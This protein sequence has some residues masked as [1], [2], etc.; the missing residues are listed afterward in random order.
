MLCVSVARHGR[1]DTNY[2]RRY[3]GQAEVT[4]EN[5]LNLKQWRLRTGTAFG[6]ATR[7]DS[8]ALSL[9]STKS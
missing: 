1:I 7:E 5:S 9:E 6:Q 4:I 3:S 8:D 2:N